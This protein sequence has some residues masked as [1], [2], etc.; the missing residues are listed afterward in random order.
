[1]V[2]IR[3]AKSDPE[4][5]TPR[6]V[7][8]RLGVTDHAVRNA[9]R[10]GR[11]QACVKDGGGKS[12]WLIRAEHAAAFQVRS[13]PS[14][15]ANAEAVSSTY[16]SELEA[17]LDRSQRVAEAAEYERLRALV[18]LRTAERDANRIALDNAL[19]EIG[20]LRRALVALASDAAVE[21][22]HG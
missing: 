18:E 9:I 10:T 12:R 4:W 21:T 22:P 17:E 11:L 1:M 7:A 19:N 16:T 14:A 8:A 20:R 15:H 6:E 3:N 5:L 13:V 2:E